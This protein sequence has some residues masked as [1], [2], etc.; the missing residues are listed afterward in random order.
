MGK[1]SSS[2]L[3]SA[4]NGIVVFALLIPCLLLPTLKAATRQD[5]IKEQVLVV[6]P[7]HATDSKG[8][9][10]Y[11]LLARDQVKTPPV[12]GKFKMLEPSK[13]I[14]PKIP[15]SSRMHHGKLQILI[16]GVIT[17]DG[18]VIDINVLNDDGDSWLAERCM[19]AFQQSTYKPATL[20]EKPIAVLV[21][22]PYTFNFK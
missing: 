12:P 18:H 2:H 1:L 3:K 14:R 11:D 4:I 7:K 16:E 6:S 5:E 10:V 9:I 22:V 13:L 15:Y 21:Q 8:E 17:A 20:D 19:K